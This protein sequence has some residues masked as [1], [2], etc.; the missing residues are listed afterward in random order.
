[1]SFLALRVSSQDQCRTSNIFPKSLG[2][3]SSFTTRWLTRGLLHVLRPV[4]IHVRLLLH[5]L[6]YLHQ[7]LLQLQY[8]LNLS[9]SFPLDLRLDLPL[10]LHLH[11]H[12]HLPHSVLLSRS[13]TNGNTY[14]KGQEGDKFNRRRDLV[15]RRGPSIF[16][17]C[18]G[19]G[20]VVDT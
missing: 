1:M 13:S 14:K 9:L 5:P 11:L 12:L 18:S 17:F 19:I 7:L 16:R 2:N 4:F 20:S 10:H 8:P 15:W 6:L 3:S